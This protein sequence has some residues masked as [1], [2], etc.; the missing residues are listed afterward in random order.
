MPPKK[1]SRSQPSLAGKVYCFSGFRDKEL[2]DLIVAAGGTVAS[3]VTKAVTDVVCKN[4]DQ[5]TKK[6]TDAAAK[7]LNIVTREDLES[8]LKVNFS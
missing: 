4:G 6:V 7:G 5:N 8:E 3:S 1:R 2:Q